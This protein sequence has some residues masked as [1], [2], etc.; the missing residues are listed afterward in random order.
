MIGKKH[1][2]SKTMIDGKEFIAQEMNLTSIISL[3]PG[4]L[5]WHMVYFFEGKPRKVFIKDSDAKIL[6]DRATKAY[7]YQGA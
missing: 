7:Y 1:D 3:K 6:V 2:P 4:I 5:C